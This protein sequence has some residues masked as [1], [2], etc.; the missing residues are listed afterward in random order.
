MQINNLIDISDYPS[1]YVHDATDLLCDTGDLQSK[2]SGGF[3]E[4]NTLQALRSLH[5]KVLYEG[6]RRSFY[7]VILVTAGVIEETLNHI[8]YKIK[9]GSLYFIP[10]NI[11]S[12]THLWSDDIEGYQFVFD[13]DFFLL[14]EKNQV[15]LNS[16]PFFNEA[17]QPFVQLSE[18][19]Q[20]AIEIT[21]RNIT[22]EFCKSKITKND[23]LVK[24]YLNA[25]LMEVE[26]IYNSQ[27]DKVELTLSRKEQIT[28]NF[29]NLVAQ[30]A[31]K[32]KQVSEFAERL[33][34]TPHYL[35]DIIRE[36]TG[37]PASRLIQLQILSLAKSHLVQTS[38]TVSE[39]SNA[40]HFTDHS[41][42]SRFFKKHTGITPLHFRQGHTI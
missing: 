38:L 33:H 2:D 31:G 29:K 32:L 10:Q 5:K 15:R 24:L 19:E 25:L 41:Y 39:I 8:K 12:T 36:T 42:F 18:A 37:I 27:D 16:Y 11:P 3:C 7:T 26:R 34:I 21:L 6:V 17:N 23:L 1:L 30:H 20:S 13:A 22:A 28:T 14:C 40:L 35:N 4:I 9:P